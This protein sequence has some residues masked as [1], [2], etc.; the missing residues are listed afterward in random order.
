MTGITDVFKKQGFWA[1]M[2][3]GIKAIGGAL[4]DTLIQPFVDVW[5]WLK[6]TFFGNS[7]SELGLSILKG[8]VA[9]ESLM[10][11]ALISPFT[12]AWEFIKN[13]PLISHLFG[14]KG[15]DTSIKPD[16]Q[17]SITVERPSTS[18]DSKK[19]QSSLTTVMDTMNDGL[20]KQM[21]AVVNAI[22][23]LRD[24]MR[25]GSI[26]STVFLDSQKLDS[27]IGRRLGYTGALV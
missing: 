14:G 20:S 24:D 12:K 23:G 19:S 4:Y 26:T 7:P 2:W 18:L 11:S 1:A 13:L 9:V 17:A 22:N 5:N 27:A 25:N 21:A 6:K 10:I 16:A 3:F 15:L 8:I